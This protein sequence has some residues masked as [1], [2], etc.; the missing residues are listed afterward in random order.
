M[1]EQYKQLD[2]AAD[3]LHKEVFPSRPGCFLEGT[4]LPQ[5][6]AWALVENARLEIPGF[7]RKQR[8]RGSVPP[9][10]EVR[11]I[12][13]LRA[14]DGTLDATEDATTLEQDAADVEAPLPMCK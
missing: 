9:R 14:D 3:K 11:G 4:R 1:L 12:P 10:L 6:I 2:G 8:C 13:A 7:F 5:N